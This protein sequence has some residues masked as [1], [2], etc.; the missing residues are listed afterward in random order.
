MWYDEAVVYQIYTLGF[1]NALHAERDNKPR[2][3]HVLD[4]VPHIKK[5][6][7]NTIL[8]NP[9]F[10]SDYHGYDTRD[11]RLVDKRL[12]T[13]EELAAVCNKL[14]DEGFKILF[15]GVFNHVGRNFFAFLDVREKKWDS[16]YKDWFYINFDGNTAYNDGFY[17]EAWEG[18]YELVKLNLRNDEVCQ[19]IFDSI[20]SYVSDYNIDGLRLDVAYCL[21]RDFLRKLREFSYSLKEDFVLIGE[22]LHGDYNLVMNDNAC[23]SVTN[24]ECYNGIY[25]SF[26]SS[27]MHEISYS[28]NRQFGSEQWCLYTGRHL[29]SFVDNHDVTRIMSILT[30]KNMINPLYALLFA[31]PG[32]PS[33]YYGS[34]WG[35]EGDKVN[36]DENLRPFIETPVENELFNFVSKLAHIKTSSKALCYGN[37]YNISVTPK[38]LIFGRWCE[39]EKVI[40]LIN[41]DSG[42]YHAY[43]DAGSSLAADLITGNEIDFKDGVEIHAYSCMYL[44]CR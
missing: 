24:Y 10:E 13:N 29:L 32:V 12:G 20:R 25:S 27:N 1:C 33:I 17:Y 34:E 30:D 18:C 6:G 38:Q 26:N 43:F 44:K 4:F 7:C 5:L 42:P 31:M 8:F 19:Y 39:E 2:I 41:S 11:M 28:L 14:H 35:I 15:D 16:K 3:N 40:V 22:T 9:L 37:Y 36:G 21:D 23:H